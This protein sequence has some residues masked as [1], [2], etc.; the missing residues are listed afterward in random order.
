MKKII[1]LG[2]MLLATTLVAQMDDQY[3][4]KLGGYIVGSQN[5]EVRLDNI[6]SVNGV[7]AVVNLQE[8]FNMQEQQQVLRFDGRYRIN[9]HHA[10]EA[11]WYSIN[12][13]GS[14]QA[15][16][17][18]SIGDRDILAGARIAS[19][20]DT[21]IFKINYVYSFYHTDEVELGIGA[22]LHA[23][24]IDFGLEGS[25]TV[26][27]DPVNLGDGGGTLKT[28]APLP[29][30]SFRFEYKVLDDFFV[31]YATDLFFISI[32][33]VSGSL[34]D[35][36]LTAEYYFSEHYGVGAGFNT[37]RMNLT[38]PGDNADL[39]LSHDVMGALVYFTL[40]Y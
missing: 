27:G 25:A 20:I 32:D 9:E 22:G 7:G 6:K 36:V 10:I 40:K 2:L 23:M 17:N 14:N 30:V 15:D 11:A 31:N 19:H 28:L 33:G 4:L 13:S 38:L 26:N 29:V 24:Q 3:K 39:G 34:S 12:S 8:L 5:T 37:T 16:N 1:S 21:N 35:S 18:F